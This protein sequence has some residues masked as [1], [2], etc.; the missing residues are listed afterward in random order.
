MPLVDLNTAI[1]HLRAEAGDPRVQPLLD[2]A[3]RFAFE[4]LDRNVYADAG[5]LSTAIAAAPAALAAAKAA[6]DA[7]MIAAATLTDCELRAK[8]EDYAA[9]AWRAAQAASDRA[10]FGIVLNADITAGILLQLEHL[11]DGSDTDKAAAALLQPY[12]RLGA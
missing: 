10:Q 4:L 5:A 7:A 11:Y 9:S 1:A 2:A 12:R 8:A 6:Y 3:E